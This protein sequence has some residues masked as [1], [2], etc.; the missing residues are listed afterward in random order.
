MTGGRPLQD[1]P[2]A[3]FTHDLQAQASLTPVAP[4]LLLVALLLL[5]VDVA[6]R[7]LLVTRS[8]LVRLRD[9]VLRRGSAIAAEPTERIS[10]LMGAKARAQQQIEEQGNTVSALRA[11]RVERRG[12]SGNESPPPPPPSRGS[13][14]SV[15][16]GPVK[17]DG[18]NIAGALLKRRKEREP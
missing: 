7:R 17:T 8:D 13:Q 3:A 15:P 2:A 12:T 1:D 10:S 4:L 5:P 16:P 14:P 9:N 6:V 11:S 18:E